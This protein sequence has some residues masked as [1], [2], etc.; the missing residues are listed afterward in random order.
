[1]VKNIQVLS[2][3]N[4]Y[5]T[6]DYVQAA[7]TLRGKSARKRIV[8]YVESY[9]DVLFWRMVLSEFEDETRYF[10]VMLPSRGNLKRGKK[11][12]LMSLMHQK[13]GT[14]M[15]ACVD[16]DYDYLLQ[17]E[18]TL[19]KFMLSN[20]YVLHTYVYAIENYQC[21]APGLHNVCV[22][23]TLNDHEVF[24][25]VDF[26]AQ[27][28]RIV[29]PLFV[30]SVMLYREGNYGKFTI[31]DF[32]TIVSIRHGRM[33]D[34]P[35]A[36][37]KLRHKVRVRVQSL[38]RELPGKKEDYLKT[39]DL[40]L[41]LGVTPETT[42]MYVQGHHLFNNVVVP[43]LQTVCDELRREREKDI[44]HKSC[45]ALQMQNELSAYNNSQSDISQMLKK[46]LGY[47]HSAPYKRLLSDVE[48]MLSKDGNGNGYNND[49]KD[50]LEQHYQ[51]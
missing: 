31:T 25:F 13:V 45:H 12:A 21:Y 39:K 26:L 35:N 1:M 11:Q 3:L 37:N 34:V 10:E 43:T 27:Y 15:I 19:S 40:L 5:I 9:D 23:S 38:Q 33:S 17:G 4:S 42:Y 16:A 32:N 44:R 30:W 7:N 50:N 20:P 6:S 36:L 48:K 24:D 46:S 49:N 2:K 51:S 8:A 47:T 22:M 41:Q 18:T 14:H 29:F 28:S